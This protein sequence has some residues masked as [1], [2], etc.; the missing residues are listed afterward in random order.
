MISLNN[1]NN[2]FFKHRNDLIIWVGLF[3]AAALIV[4]LVQLV[5][6]PHVFPSWHAG[7]GLMAGSDAVSFHNTAVEMAESIRNEG[8]S[9]WELRPKGW[10]PAGVAAA[11]YALSWPKPSALIP[12][13]AAVHATT[14]LVVVKIMQ[15]V[16]PAL[17]TAFTSALPF[18]FFPS[19]MLW[20][21]QIHRDGYQ[22]L[23]ITF[24]LYGLLLVIN[25]NNW[26][27]IYWPS[28]LGGFLSIIA[29]IVMVWL[30]RPHSLVILLLMSLI[31]F[32]FI[33]AV[34]F[35][36]S[37]KRVIKLK[38]VLAQLI[39]MALLILVIVPLTQA[40]D[41]S[42]YQLEAVEDEQESVVTAEEA[43]PERP[44][45][46]WERT[47][48]LPQALDDQLYAVSYLRSVRYPAKY[49]ETESGI[50]YDRS[51]HNMYDYIY[52][53]PRAL[54]IGFLAPFPDEWF[55]EGSK[56]MSVL[57][58]RA[59][60]FEMTFIY[61][62]LPFLLY[63]VWIWRKKIEMWVMII[64]CTGMMLPIVYSVPNVGTIYRYRYGYLM[65][66]VALGVAAFFE[67]LKRLRKRNRPMETFD[68][69]KR[70]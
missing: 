58:R 52:Y 29:G 59:S 19:A 45:L 49:G 26:D 64:F 36:M 12:L 4:I 54:Q 35:F 40:E 53:L 24:F 20:Y 14:F 66:L 6:L 11:I 13:N 63:G 33:G 65:L 60:A 48:W 15:F 41:A 5:A 17:K 55:G 67:L 31:L 62:A 43:D 1:K 25:Q 32:L 16:V 47:S 61:L 37:C 3:F 56:E 57:F 42:K 2:F 10:M 18:A 9:A 51:F 44:E 23:G 22:I 34:L 50:D 8:W 30:A 68:I 46:K 38:T 70:R 69:N 21:T 27:H 28:K 7:D 39:P